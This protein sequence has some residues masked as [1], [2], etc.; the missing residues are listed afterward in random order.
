VGAVV[1]APGFKTFDPN[2]RPE[3]GY[4]RFANVQTSLEFER[5]LSASGPH[6][7]HLQR[8]GDGKEPK[9]VAWLQCVGS[10][11][12]SIGK[13]YC[14]YVCCMYATKQAVIAQEHLPGLS[15]SIFYMDIR[16]QGKGFDR[17]YERARDQAG[18]NYVR[19]MVSGSW[20]TKR[21][22]I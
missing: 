7:G 14:S 8:P 2:G 22:A 9:R 1:M 13:D 15:A 4:G 21:P 18:V 11:D 20:K 3:Y 5:I 17:Y 6:G 19:S 16:A 10:R 12:A